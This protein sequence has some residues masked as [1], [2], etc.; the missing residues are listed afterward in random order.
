MMKI[1][2]IKRFMVGTLV[3]AMI[4]G[5][6][7]FSACKKTEST[8]E[9]SY[10]IKKGTIEPQGAG[11]FDIEPAK[12]KEG[13]NISL[14]VTS[15][16]LG[17]FSFNIEGLTAKRVSTTDY[18]TFTMP[19]KN[20]VVSANFVVGEAYSIHQGAVNFPGAGSFEI[21]R[22]NAREGQTVTLTLNITNEVYALDRWE[23]SVEEGFVAPEVTP[24]GTANKF[25][26]IMPGCE[27]TVALFLKDETPYDS[28]RAYVKGSVILIVDGEVVPNGLDGKNVDFTISPPSP[29]EPGDT[30][31][32]TLDIDPAYEFYRWSF[33]PVLLPPGTVPQVTENDN[34]FVF[35]MPSNALFDISLY[36]RD[37]GAKELVTQGTI[38]LAK[39]ATGQPAP[40]TNTGTNY[41]APED[42]FTAELTAVNGTLSG[43]NYQDQ[44]EYEFEFTLTAAEGYKF[45]ANN[46]ININGKKARTYTIISDDEAIVSSIYRTSFPP[47]GPRAPNFAY[48]MI[49]YSSGQ[50]QYAENLTPDKMFDGENGDEAAYVLSQHQLSGDQGTD[51]KFFAV[52][53]GQ[54]RDIGTIR[55]TWG[56]ANAGTTNGQLEGMGNYEIKV[57]PESWEGI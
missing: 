1:T 24:S 28:R 29:V 35:T 8:K 45:I 25:T 57:A 5:T 14:H 44:Q 27:L 9:V 12:A 11:D 47:A 51:P 40:L 22:E 42:N 31:T 50:T 32:L 37:Y 55:I 34:V 2:Y 23:I 7:A 53:L 6:F 4:F 26:F 52:D 33:T 56:R 19:K 43:G 16:E 48:N 18:Y 54:V 46:P 49:G 20:V 10:T 3:L 36:V 21:D 39:P 13:D 41:A 17:S 30:V 15:G 38:T